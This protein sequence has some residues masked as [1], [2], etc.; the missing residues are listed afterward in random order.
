MGDKLFSLNYYEE[1]YQ[2]KFRA[3]YIHNRGKWLVLGVT[4]FYDQKRPSH[5]DFKK[6]LKLLN[7]Q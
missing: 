2:I 7:K 3:T 5:L 6:I 1:E 4:A